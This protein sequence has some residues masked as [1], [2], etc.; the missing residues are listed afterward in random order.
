MDSYSSLN[1]RV[2]NQIV[3]FSA[4]SRISSLALSPTRFLMTTTMGGFGTDPSILICRLRDPEVH[5]AWYLPETSWD[6][7]AP[8][9]NGPQVPWRSPGPPHSTLWASAA[10]P[11]PNFLSFAIG[12]SRG[13]A[14]MSG[15]QGEWRPT[16]SRVLD[17]EGSSLAV[18]EEPD[19]LAVDWLNPNTIMS[20][21]RNG[22]AYLWDTRISGGN[23]R[24]CRLSCPSS[25][26]HIRT[27]NPHKVVVAGVQDMVDL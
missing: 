18:W 15:G 8:E 17:A 25:I 9:G 6:P 22:R 1:D 7:L 11:H 26:S 24:T 20:G 4:D 14:L 5:T 2:S 10:N 13:T 23:N 12:T 19:V 21:C 16:V 3:V 27:V